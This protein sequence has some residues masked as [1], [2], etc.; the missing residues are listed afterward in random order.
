MVT[1][2]STFIVLLVTAVMMLGV[3][4]SSKQ[5]P[6]QQA[7][8]EQKGQSTETM[9]QAA[10]SAKQPAETMEQQPAEQAAQQAAPEAQPMTME[11]T[12]T[13]EQTDDGIVL[14]TDMGNYKVMGQ[15]LSDM[16]GKTVKVTGAVEESQ[17]ELT[18]SVLSVAEAQ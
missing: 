14:A 11:L 2:R 16:V 5:G 15:D 1:F 18:I 4:C 6:A 13:V 8:E 17:G 9:D 12:G 10:E 7:A 3:A